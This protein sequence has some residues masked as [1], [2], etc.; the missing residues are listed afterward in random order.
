VEEVVVEAGQTA[1]D[2]M[3]ACQTVVARSAAG[4]PEFPE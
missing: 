3:E 2:Q 4:P 1:A